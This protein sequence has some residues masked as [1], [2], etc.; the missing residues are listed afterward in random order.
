MF[1]SYLKNRIL[2]QGQ[3]ER[4]FQ[5]A[6]ILLYFEELKCELNAEIESKVIFEISSTRGTYNM[7]H[8]SPHLTPYKDPPDPWVYSAF[9]TAG[10]QMAF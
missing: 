9:C 5:S 10:T 1:R 3:G 8:M 7:P 6:G 2:A 4:A